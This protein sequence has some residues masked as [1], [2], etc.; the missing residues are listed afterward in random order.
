MIKWLA[1]EIQR[2]REREREREFLIQ[3]QYVCLQMKQSI[4]YRMCSVIY[5][6]IWKC[7]FSKQNFNSY[8]NKVILNKKG[9]Y[10]L[11]IKYITHCVL[12]IRL[13]YAKIYAFL[14]NGVIPVSLN[15]IKSATKPE[16]QTKLHFSKRR[17]V[18][19]D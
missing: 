8:Y 17:K 1:L 9:I 18:G 4:K 3:F 13:T 15:L 10:S 19:Q 14:K 12:L 5:Y 16:Y 11:Q 6:Y 2:E 7:F